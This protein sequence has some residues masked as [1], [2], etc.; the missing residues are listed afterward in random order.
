MDERLDHRVNILEPRW[1]EI[2]VGAAQAGN[3]YWI[4]VT[5]FGNIDGDAMP[6]IADVTPGGQF[7]TVGEFTS[8][9]IPKTASTRFSPATR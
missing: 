4:L 8:E 6:P 9:A 2:G 5:D 1:D 7:A 3:G